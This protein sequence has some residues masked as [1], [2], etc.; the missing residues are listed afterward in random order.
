MDEILERVLDVE[1]RI[2]DDPTT[3]R[4]AIRRMLLDGKI[5]MHP[6]ADGS[7]RAESVI[8]PLRLPKSRKPRNQKVSEASR[9]VVGNDG[10]AGRI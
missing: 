3:A 8:F 7:Y 6:E 2:T 5:V 10:C 4:E 9:D 1:A